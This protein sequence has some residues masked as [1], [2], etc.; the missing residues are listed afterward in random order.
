MPL[1][2]LRFLILWTWSLAT[3]SCHWEKV[4]R[5]RQHFG[6]LIHMGRIDYTLM[7]FF[8]IQ[9]E[10]WT[11]KISKNHGLGVG[12]VKCYIDVIIIFLLNLR[13]SYVPFCK[14]CLEDLKNITLSFIQ[15]CV[16]SFILRWNT[17]VTWFIQVDWGFRRPRLRSFH[18]FHN[19]QISINYKL[20]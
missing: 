3:I 1:V 16:K 13:K 8:A 17:W 12:F 4:I 5:S 14:R 7:E 9:F 19:Q 2:R 18:K 6:K 15:T 10:E 20:L 11:Y